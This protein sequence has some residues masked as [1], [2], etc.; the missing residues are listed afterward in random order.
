MRY[1]I[2]DIHGEY[3]LFCRL[4]EKIR[5]SDSDELFVC[6]DIIEKGKD[7]VKL[8]RLIFSMPNV[9]VIMGNHEDAFI[10]YY[11]FRMR[12]SDGDFEK[13][14]DELKE[15]ISNS[16]GDGEL[17][18][19]DVVDRIEE[20]PYYI[21]TDDFICVHAGLSL[22]GDGKVPPLAT[23]S[24]EE[25]VCS[26]RFKNADVIPK[27]SKC[28]FFGHTATSVICGEN[29]IIGYKK[30]GSSFGDVRDYA[31]IHLDTCTFISGVL[32]C[33]CIDNCK[34]YYVSRA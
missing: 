9:H 26:R 27:D 33:F 29:K 3:E 19:W 1:V 32:G 25:L 5:F 7:S 18:D 21:E 24:A 8:A 4:L 30:D 11:N 22:D 28:V 23:V 14:L 2:S 6:G 20:L 16:G 34:V 10:K 17:L 12:E 31:K 15:Y 13:V